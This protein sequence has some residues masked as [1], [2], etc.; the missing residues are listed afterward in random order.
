L[1]IQVTVPKMAPITM[2]NDATAAVLIWWQALGAVSVVNVAAWIAVAIS[3]ERD[4]ERM[5]PPLYAE[6]RWQLLLSAVFV[7]GCAFRSVLP[8]AEGQRICLYDSWISSAMI[9]RWVATVAELCLV[10]QL[11][12]ILHQYAK[13]ARDARGLRAAWLPLPLIALAELFSWYTAL[14]TNFIGSVIEESIWALTA[15]IMTLAFVGMWPRHAG[16]Q[17]RFIGGAIV[18]NLAYMAFMCTV[19]VPMYWSRWQADQADGHRYLSLG[20]GWRD[21]QRRRVVTRRWEDWRAEIPWMSLY[22]SAAVWVSIGLVRA[23]DGENRT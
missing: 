15:G 17:R 23:P 19:D 1:A 12:M 7:C 14:T 10:G 9:G 22:F 4:E 21:S 8:R 11:T 3:L 2:T 5:P 20:E 6:R 13:G 16:R 18:L